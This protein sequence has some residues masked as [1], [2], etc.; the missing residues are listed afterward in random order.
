MRRDEIDWHV[1]SD[2]IHHPELE[3]HVARGRPLRRPVQAGSSA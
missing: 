2:R 3:Q 1:A